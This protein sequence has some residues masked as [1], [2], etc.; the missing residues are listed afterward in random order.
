MEV[1]TGD[2]MSL[3]LNVSSGSPQFIIASRSFGSADQLVLL[4]YSVNADTNVRSQRTVRLAIQTNPYTAPLA[5]IGKYHRPSKSSQRPKQARG[6]RETNDVTNKP[7]N[8]W[9]ERFG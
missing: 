2:D 1:Y 7:T 6:E 5:S 8:E 4:I 3:L 9:L